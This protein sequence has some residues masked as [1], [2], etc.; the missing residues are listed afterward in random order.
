[1]V[2][3]FDIQKCPARTGGAFCCRRIGRHFFITTALAVVLWFLGLCG[4]GGASL[5]SGFAETVIPGP[6]GGNWNDAVG[7]NFESN[8]RMWIWERTG[9]VWF[10]DPGDPS[11]TLLLDISEEVGAWE[12]HGLLGFA[13][14]PNFRINGRIYLLYVVDR[15]YLL[16]FG[17]PGYNPNSNQYNA[18][19]IG[20]LTRY[21]CTSSNG[22][23][24]V[25][26]GSRFI[27]VGESK[28]NGFPILSYTH[29]IGTLVFG[30]DGTLL[31]SCGDG[32]TADT[33]D[34]G[35][36]VSGSYAPQGLADGIIRPKEN[37]GGLRSQLLDC[38]NGK[39]VRLDPATGN[40]WTNNP[41]YDAAN[42]RSAR[43]R[44]WALGLRNPFRMALKENSGSHNP[45]DANPGVLFAGE[46]GWNTWESL[47]VITSPGQNFGWPLYEGLSTTP[48]YD[49]NVANQDAPNPLY[50]G[51]G[52]SQYFTFANL[53]KEDTLSPSGQPP[54][55]N[56]CNPAQKIPGSIPQFL[57]TRPVL[58]WNHS[59]AITRTP[60]YGGG[61]QAQT[62]N[63]GAGGSPVS[64]TAFSGNCAVG[65]T[66]YTASN[67]PAAYQNRFYFAD[68][69]Q[70]LIKTLTFDTNHNPVAL[71]SFASGAGY[72]VSI[73]QHP[74]DGS[75][76]YLGYNFAGA[77]MQRLEYIGNRTPVAV[78]SANT[79]FGTTPLTV[80][81]SSE[82]SSDPDGQPITFSW[83]FG[84]GSLVSTQAS[85]L[86]TFTAPTGVPTKYVVTLTVTDSG[87]LSAQTTLIVSVNNAPPNVAI[88]SPTNASLY[89]TTVPTSINLTANVTDA[90]SSDSQLQYQWQVLFHHNDHDHGNL[91]DTNH[92]TSAIMEPTSCD[93]INIYYY[94][95]LLTVTD[96]AGLSTVREV[97]MFPDCGPNTPATISTISNQTAFPGTPI[98]P[99]PFT[100]GDAE[101]APANLQLSAGSSNPAL[102]PTNSIVFGGSGANRTLTLTPKAGLTG[103]STI[104][105]KVNDGP[106]DTTNA[107]LL[108]VIA[109]NAAPTISAIGDQTVLTNTSTPALVF[110]VSDLETPAASLTL[111]NAS[112]NPALVPTNNIVFGG[113]GSNR[114]VTVTPVPG[115]SGASAISLFVSDG[116]NTASTAFQLNVVT[117]LPQTWSF[118][119]AASITIRDTNS[120]LPYPSTINVAGLPGIVSNVTVTLRGF[121]HT[122]ADDVDVLLVGP[123]GTNVLLMSDAGQGPESNLTLTFS[124][125]AA[126]AVPLP[127]LASGTY[128]PANY[129]DASILGDNFPNPA[130]SGPFGS[131]LS[132]FNGTAP[133]GTWSLYFLDDGPADTGTVA[134]GWTL[135]IVTQAAPVTNT[136][137]T[138]SA[139]SNQVTLVNMP[140]AALPFTIGDAETA[141]SSLVLTAFSSNTGLVP[142]NQIAFSGSGASRMVT[143]TPASNQL[144]SA[145]ITLQVSDG[146]LNASNSFVLAVNP[147][148]L[149]ITENSAS[150][151]YGLTNPPLSGS[152]TGLQAG[153]NITASFSSPAN[154]NSAVGVYPINFTLS[155]PGA[156]L[157]NYVIITNHGTLTVT[158]ALLTVTAHSTN[159]NYGTLHAFA[160]S[161]F[162]VTSGTL[163]N[164]DAITNVAFAST[165]ANTNA[166]VGVHSIAVTNAQGAGLSNYLVSY[167]S[168]T[169]TVNP[170]PL[171]VAAD[172]TNKVY[173]VAWTFAGAEFTISSGTL[174]NGNTLTNVT[175]ASAGTL[176]NAPVGSYTIVADGALG[177]GLTNYSISYSNGTLTVAKANLIA[178]ADN[179]SRTY[180][181][182][183]P[184]F[185][186]GFSGFVNGEDTNVLNSLPTAST[187]ATNTT[188]PGDYLIT[189][190]GGSD[191]NYSF[192]LLP[193]TLTILPS[194]PITIG[195]V[196]I[197]ESG[198]FRLT[199]SGDADVTYVIQF[200]TDLQTWS[201]LGTATADGVGVFEFVD[202]A[203]A[204]L[205]KCF[206]RVRTP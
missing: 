33:V 103:T 140:T 66:W 191:D 115:Q 114:T 1:M 193:G 45:A 118:T 74:A 173:G 111:S 58:D 55:D 142:T 177:L 169:L 128:R 178:A 11:Y 71:G 200:S 14:D 147:A 171:T 79:N 36:V 107:F 203:T 9:K 184:V 154:T 180:G 23:R 81:L 152:L 134:T 125:A 132:V 139:V 172:S 19:T 92:I 48:G 151:G 186:I 181:Q 4:A 47:K 150:R 27:L 108:T 109:T 5:P 70:G 21:T 94:R 112:S 131:T 176:S 6:A 98:G 37:I 153:D 44:V 155:D 160:G 32:A 192:T 95:V 164:G 138:I 90:E 2:T 7:L 18:A 75:L 93:G 42:P 86:H 61:G 157:G 83:N 80:Q 204:S 63:V 124:D 65:G 110:T 38:L 76:Y 183:N 196:E 15:Y 117:A 67:F 141:A 25:D 119:N 162:S 50:P 202:T 156:K 146:V 13:L 16:N 135:T 40:A 51:G 39:V 197:N 64:G 89:S 102:V 49:G 158:N 88:T 34:Q 185:T 12:D 194:G 206:Y 106:N 143:V 99:I 78:A 57:R 136:P 10:K 69:G 187:T 159:K 77:T 84:D 145:T 205:D 182:P 24:S 56:P 170:A 113:S 165:G 31:A 149:T 133:N 20:R 189:L 168:G 62:A 82:G 91:A 121:S 163:F 122:W 101:V 68:W 53:L 198:H 59:S 129:T 201:L 188:V 174:F 167:V 144:G 175:L 97:R 190:S 161:E 116:T 120:A 60:T 148:T 46:V 28:T 26:L 166:P 104:T 29:G 52:C 199:G 8:G 130:P 96:P 126:S 43:S 100:I 3:E 22:F 17:T 54:F 179:G 105:V 137:P 127:N 41:F 72:V 87:G 73:V 35:G 30:Q 123:G 195:T 85:P